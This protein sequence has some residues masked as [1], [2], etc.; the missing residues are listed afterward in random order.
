MKRSILLA[1]CAM[2]SAFSARANNEP[3]INLGLTSFLD[4]APPAG[5]GFYFTEYLL[6]YHADRF[7]DKDGHGQQIPTTSSGLASPKLDIFVSLNQLIYQSN[8]KV[9]L[10]G[11]WGVD[12]ILPVVNFDLDP[13]NLVITDNGAGIGDL[14]IGPYLQWDPIMGPKG[15]VFVHRV[16]FQC[17]TPTGRYNKDQTLNPGSN[18]FSFNPYWAATWFPTPKCELSWRIH[19]LWNDKSDDTKFQPGQAVHLNFA[20]SYELI[21]KRLRVGINGYYLK[22]FTDTQVNG[23]NQPGRDQ[24]F[25]LGPGLLYSFSQ[26]DH[27]FF[28]AYYEMAAESRTEGQACLLRW[29]HHF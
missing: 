16:E 10:G 19:Y 6:Y 27:L 24:V 23:V 21:A 5:P 12:F 22:Q 18:F 25:A 1:L 2:L 20:S 26:N 28:N 14:V 4:G 7:T 3:L 15:P 11:K 13:K 29:V 17:I 9:F 8:Q